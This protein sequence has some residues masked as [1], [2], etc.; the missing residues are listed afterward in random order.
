MTI[1][2]PKEE[3]EV[4]PLQVREFPDDMLKMVTAPWI[5]A[6]NEDKFQELLDS[7]E[8][9]L[10]VNQALGLAGPQVGLPYRIIA[11][12]VDKE[13]LVLI[14]PVIEGQS[15]ATESKAEGCLSFPGLAL[16]VK[17]P[18]NVL[19]SYMTRHGDRKTQDFTGETARAVQH[20]IDHLDG[21][22]FIDR[23]PKVMRSGVMRKWQ[24]APRVARQRQKQMEKMFKDFKLQKKDVIQAAPKVDLPGTTVIDAG[25]VLTKEV[26]EQ[27]VARAEAQV[28]T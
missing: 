10:K 25:D 27:A 15:I 28:G 12:R 26:I 11:V 6:V 22:V 23:I 14:N 8:L 17:R 18:L 4:Y 7:F 5:K 2:M 16:K 24:L 9:T 1:E 19:V 20:E 21:V 13:P 3:K